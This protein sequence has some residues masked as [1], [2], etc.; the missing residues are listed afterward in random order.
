MNPYI[1][2]EDAGPIPMSEEKNNYSFVKPPAPLHQHSEPKKSCGCVVCQC[3]T[4]V[5]S[6]AIG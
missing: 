3:S 5:K 2:A 1:P 6:F 4:N